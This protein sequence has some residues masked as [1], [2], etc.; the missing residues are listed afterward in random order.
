VADPKAKVIITAQ[1]QTGPAIRSAERNMRSLLKQGELV[2]KFFKGGAIVAAVVAFERLAE[3]A[4]K[5]ALAVGDKGTARALSQL[6]REIDNLK[7]K[8]LNL[9]GKVLGGIYAEVSEGN[10]P[11][12]RARKQLETLIELRRQ[13]QSGS[14]LSDSNTVRPTGAFDQLIADKEAELKRLTERL[15]RVS[16]AIHSPGGRNR[17]PSTHGETDSER[18]KR[19]KEELERTF[20]DIL[21]TT[22]R[23][24]ESA[25]EQLYRG[26]DE[27]T[28]TGLQRQVDEW[29][30]F[31]SQ[32]N[33]LLAS[34]RISPAEAAKRLLAKT[35]E[36]LGDEG[37]TVT[38]KR[39][40]PEH[41]R[42]QLNAFAE[43]AA[44]GMQ[45]A[46]A[47]FFFDPFEKGIKG[48]LASFVDVI[49]RMAAELFAQQVLTG[50]FSLGTKL[51]GV[52]GS[53]SKSLLGSI[54]GKATGGPVSGGTPYM[55]GERGPELFVPGS[56]GAIVPNHAMGGA[57]ITY[58]IDARGA[59]AERI[60]S[61]MPGLLKQTEDRT[62]ARIRD[63]NGRG[64]L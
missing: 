21:V 43:E 2:G 47:D 12:E 55:V 62:I 34:G 64:R 28:Q 9:I 61:V 29:I 44:R 49:R 10:T 38:A 30:K 54:T 13:A 26:M 50:F 18:A 31:E 45:N 40:F 32:V 48:M 6:N 42:E 8:G 5:A 22:Q 52:V 56:S 17:T 1:D 46:F 20:P 57:S 60:M 11:I 51:P 59:D 4:E 23:I 37:T 24:T 27:A 16:F 14:A 35:N 15:G 19:I 25:M 41:E 36:M 7:S 3:N 39:L 53:F 58:N 63:M 33:E